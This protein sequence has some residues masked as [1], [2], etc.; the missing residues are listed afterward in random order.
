MYKPRFQYYPLSGLFDFLSEKPS[1]E[2]SVDLTSPRFLS[3]RDEGSFVSKRIKWAGY[4]YGDPVAVSAKERKTDLQLIL[5]S[6][7]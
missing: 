4:A 5:S 3:L 1:F 7:L 2:P 6:V